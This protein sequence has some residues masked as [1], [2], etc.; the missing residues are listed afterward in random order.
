MQEGPQGEAQ[1]STEATT[2]TKDNGENPAA[3]DD[4][5]AGEL[6]PVED[7]PVEDGPVEAPEL[8]KVSSEENLAGLDE[9]K[10]AGLDEENAAKAEAVPANTADEN[11]VGAEPA[12]ASEPVPI[13]RKSSEVMIAQPGMAP[14]NSPGLGSLALDDADTPEAAP[15]PEPAPGAQGEWPVPAWSS[16]VQ[17]AIWQAIEYTGP[18]PGDE[19]HTAEPDAFGYHVEISVD[20]LYLQLQVPP[21]CAACTLPARAATCFDVLRGTQCCSE[22][23]LCCDCRAKGAVCL[24]LT[25]LP[26][27]LSL[28]PLPWCRSTPS[29]RTLQQSTFRR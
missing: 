3:G 24:S 25:P 1:P 19:T 8:T 7:G 16:D 18:E 21:P 20:E 6:P 28:T 29:P 4:A 5:P 13:T 2:R 22:V 27:C 26:V 10:L 23:P 17:A 9:E 14:V 11:L 15:M 12:S